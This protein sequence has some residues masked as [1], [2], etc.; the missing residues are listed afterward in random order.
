MKARTA[1]LFA[2]GL[3]VLGSVV[4]SPL[5]ANAACPSSPVTPSL[6]GTEIRWGATSYCANGSGQS[7]GN[8]HAFLMHYYAPPI[9]DTSPWYALDTTGPSFSAFGSECDN[10]GTTT[11][12]TRSLH[13]TGDTWRNSALVTLNHC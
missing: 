4:A 7:L 12:Y 5:A 1:S 2:A 11:Y 9:P 8:L 6:Q 3:M 10:G 13:S